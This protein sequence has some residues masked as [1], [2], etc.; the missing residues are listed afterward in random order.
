M[1]TREAM[2]AVC[3]RTLTMDE[4]GKG[5]LQLLLDLLMAKSDEEME[6]AQERICELERKLKDVNHELELSQMYDALE[7]EEETP[8]KEAEE[9]GAPFARK[10]EILNSLREKMKRENLTQ[11]DISAMTGIAPG[12][13]SPILRGKAN[14]GKDTLKR[15][16]QLLKSG[17]ETA[18]TA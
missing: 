5:A 14:P 1:M 13:L 17:A 11:K 12:T 16:E 8:Q 9:P 18:A 6:R 7:A 3:A 2:I 4:K 15:L 10:E